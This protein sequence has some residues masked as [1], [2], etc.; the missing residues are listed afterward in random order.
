LILVRLIAKFWQLFSMHTL[1]KVSKLLHIGLVEILEP[2]LLQNAERNCFLTATFLLFMFLGFQGMKPGHSVVSGLHSLVF[3]LVANFHQFKVALVILFHQIGPF[4][5]VKIRLAI[6]FWN[7]NIAH[8][9]VLLLDYA[10]IMRLTYF[11]FSFSCQT[12]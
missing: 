5:V 7:F 2:D 1:C 8:A 4:E 9:Y 3:F 11:N 10:L 12:H 6:E